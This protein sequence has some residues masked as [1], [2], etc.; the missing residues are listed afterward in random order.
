M[1]RIEYILKKRMTIHFNRI[2]SVKTGPSSE[3]KKVTI[4]N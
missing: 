1:D 2:F 4:M 3:E